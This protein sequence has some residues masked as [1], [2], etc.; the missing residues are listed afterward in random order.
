MVKRDQS[1]RF[2]PVNRPG[3]P[4][5]EQRYETWDDLQKRLFD[6]TVRRMERDA[7]VQAKA[8]E[9]CEIKGTCR[10]GPNGE[11]PYREVADAIA[12]DA[13]TKLHASANAHRRAVER[14]VRE[15]GSWVYDDDLPY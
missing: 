4:P 13:K 1:G 11:S 3:G 2:V 14:I 9:V 5:L 10:P 8:F 7:P 15:C 6:A 12:P